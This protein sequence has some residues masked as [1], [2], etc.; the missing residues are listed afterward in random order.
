MKITSGW[1]QSEIHLDEPLPKHTSTRIS[2]FKNEGC[3]HVCACVHIC[4]TCLKE[5]K[6]Y[7]S[8]EDWSCSRSFSFRKEKVKRWQKGMVLGTR[9]KWQFLSTCHYAHI[10]FQGCPGFPIILPLLL[11]TTRKLTRKEGFA[12][13]FSVNTW[14][15]QPIR[16][17]S[18]L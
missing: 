14:Q 7:W 4:I 15:S 12:R 17:S 6:R 10:C 16:K 3:V 5:E 11:V 1:Y 2:Y 9:V 8:I 13:K 18:Q